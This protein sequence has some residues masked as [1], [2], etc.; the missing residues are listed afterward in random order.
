MPKAIDALDY[1]AKPAKS[2]ASPITVLFGDDDFLKRT[3]LAEVKQQVLSGDDAEFSVS[4]F[5]G[6]D[7]EM[8]DVADALSMRALFGGGRPLVVIEEADEFVS[9][10]RASLEN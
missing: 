10:N 6:G 9:E 4:T 5:Q 3:V 8:R 7:V 2:P 1:L